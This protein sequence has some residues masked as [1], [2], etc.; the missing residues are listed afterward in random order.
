MVKRKLN[1]FQGNNNFKTIVV[2]FLPGRALRPLR[3]FEDFEKFFFKQ[4]AKKNG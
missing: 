1:I 2:I 4:P 3:L